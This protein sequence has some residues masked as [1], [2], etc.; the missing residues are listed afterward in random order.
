MNS[1]V[2]DVFIKA[3]AVLSDLKTK[4]ID[5][6][7]ERAQKAREAEDMMAAEE[8]AVTNTF[9]ALFSDWLE[10]HAKK[11]K[12]TWEQDVDFHRRYLSAH[13]DHRPVSEI[14]RL[15]ISN[16]LDDIAETTA[17]TADLATDLL[18][19]MWNWAIDSGRAEVNPAA[20]QR[21]RHD[22]KPRTRVLTDEEIGI[23]WHALSTRE[24]GHQMARAIKLLI[25]TG[26][27]VNEVI[28]SEWNEISG[29]VWIKPA[30]RMKNNDPHTVPLT[31]RA[32]RI[33]LE[34][35]DQSR[36]NGSENIFAGRTGSGR[37]TFNP[38][39]CSRATREIMKLVGIKASAHDFR[40]TIATRLS[41]VGAP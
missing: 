10:Q 6:Q 2:D 23:V 17:R 32:R 38:K 5:P 26:A 22:G 8:A 13:L 25:L 29:D 41:E 20:R 34:A 7:E 16:V 39:A 24:R 40:R 31:D 11:R 21:P 36:K 30:I 28:G 1:N 9:A 3:T 27:R 19:S 15:E 4:G 33:F 14:T 37:E 12:K 18:S 35:G